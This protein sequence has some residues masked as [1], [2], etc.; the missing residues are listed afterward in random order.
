VKKTRR[1]NHGRK[2]E[3]KKANQERI[4]K[5]DEENRVTMKLELQASMAENG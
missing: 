1:T 5:K 2:E 3:K 4:A